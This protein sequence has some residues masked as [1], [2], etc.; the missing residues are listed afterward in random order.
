M[1]Q[2]LDIPG[3]AIPNKFQD[4]QVIDASKTN[5][6]NDIVVNKITEII[7]Q[8]NAHDTDITQL[9][10][11]YQSVIAPTIGEIPN[12][13]I[14]LDKLAN[15]TKTAFNTA[16]Y[17]KKNDV[18]PVLSVPDLLNTIT[19]ND[20]N[21][22]SRDNVIKTSLALENLNTINNVTD[23]AKKNYG[24]YIAD[25]D[26]KLHNYYG[27]ETIT[28]DKFYSKDLIDYTKTTI[29]YSQ[30]NVTLSK[31]A[32]LASTLVNISSSVDLPK[33][34]DNNDTTYADFL[35]IV[36]QTP[37][38][39]AIST[40]SY[41]VNCIISG[42][43]AKF[44]CY[45]TTIGTAEVYKITITNSD[46]SISI[47]EDTLGMGSILTKNYTFDAKFVKKVTFQCSLNQVTNGATIYETIMSIYNLSFVSTN[48]FET[49]INTCKAH[50]SAF[51]TLV[52]DSNEATPYVVTYIDSASV[53]HLC[54]LTLTV[55]NAVTSKYE[56]KYK[57]TY[58][59]LT[60]FSTSVKFRVANS[61][62]TG[63]IISG[64]YTG[65][66][67]TLDEVQI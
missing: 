66:Y 61:N 46:D 47:L 1:A 44:R 22:K 35:A 18:D 54:T 8:S 29:P 38:V 11:D 56:H 37:S 67:N 23:F 25:A 17:L 21:S 9:K 39:T 62:T 10:E 60:N 31:Q 12:A 52:N 7:E 43:N 45:N 30:F 41:D 55:L 48:I 50:N 5:A 40:I 19:T 4:L 28:Y 27:L 57:F 59:D 51:I 36:G 65:V 63:K 49:K 34:F 26:H 13:S 2:I 20:T 6:N 32:L 14:T 33:V 53:E 58:T 24:D 42:I 16:T 15:E 64:Y 3:K